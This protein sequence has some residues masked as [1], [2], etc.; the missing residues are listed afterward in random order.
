MAVLHVL[1]LATQQ[2]RNL[3][4]GEIFPCETVNVIYG[5]NAQGKT[6]LLEGLWLFTG[7]RSFRGAKDGEL[8]RMG[9]DSHG[10]ASLS[11]TFWAGGREQQGEIHLQGGRRRASLNGVSRRSASAMVGAF[12]A[13]V[14]S[15]DHLSLVKDGPTE[16][17]NFLD[18]A[19]C[20]LRPAYASLLNRYQR[21]LQQRNALL[22]DIPRHRELLDTLEIWDDRLAGFGGAIMEERLRYVELLRPAAEAIYGGI[23]R[24]REA[25]GLEYQMTAAPKV[26]EPGSC[27]EALSRAL[28][29]KRRDDLGAGFTTAGP[30][31]DDLLLTVNGAAARSFGSQGQQRSVV[32][33]LKLAEAAVLEKALG[34]PP[35][36]LLDDVMSELDVS[37]QEYLLNQ[38]EG[39]QIFITCCDPSSVRLLEKGKVF[40]VQAGAVTQEAP[41]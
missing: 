29:Q 15:P 40:T 31:R 6:N 32:L 17:R 24:E 4:D 13:V 39:R 3:A 34:E 2:F 9:E 26:R 37:R 14:F 35:V 12:C 11:L 5:G 33:S 23:S 28:S 25:L 10:A 16:R 18:G 36:V 30:H 20:Q 8:V 19:I 7:G 1:R 21:T 41:L 27:R 22:K 38:M